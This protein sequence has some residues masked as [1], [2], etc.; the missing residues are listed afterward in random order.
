MPKLDARKLLKDVYT[1]TARPKLVQVPPLM[2]FMVDGAGD[3]N[4]SPDFPLAVEMLYTLSYTLKFERKKTDPEQDY[5]VMPL[6]GLWWADSLDDFVNLNKANWHWTLMIMQPPRLTQAQF[7]ALREL[8]AAR[9]P[10]LPFAKVELAK[11]D[12]SLAAQVMHIGP[13]AEEGPAIQR[14][15]EFIAAQGYAPTGKH[16]EIYLSDPRRTPEAK[17]KTILRQPCRPASG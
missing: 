7:G 16:Q 2:Y 6:E 4:L 12:G 3:P 9:K 5:T 13:F 15:H 10:D 8:A 11:L 17:W 1:A 14:L